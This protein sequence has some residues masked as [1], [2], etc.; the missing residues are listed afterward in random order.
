MT[1]D[2]ID[3]TLDVDGTDDPI[4]T[5][6]V[7]SPH[8]TLSMMGVIELT[9]RSVALREVHIGGAGSGHWERRDCAV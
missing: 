8:G 5:I 3:L 4:V 2:H 6:E 7:R 9:E 1:P